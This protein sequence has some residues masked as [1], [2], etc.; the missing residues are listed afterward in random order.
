MEWLIVYKNGIENVCRKETLG[1]LKRFIQLDDSHLFKGRLQLNK[2]DGNVGV[3]VNGKLIGIIKTED[4]LR[5]L[6]EVDQ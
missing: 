4:F 3:E 2:N 5:C 1:N 6:K